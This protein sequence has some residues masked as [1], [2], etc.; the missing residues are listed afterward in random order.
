MA[1]VAL[2]VARERHHLSREF[3]REQRRAARDGVPQARTVRGGENVWLAEWVELDE[4]APA[5]LEYEAR[6]AEAESECIGAF[7]RTKARWAGGSRGEDA[8]TWYAAPHRDDF[9]FRTAMFGGVPAGAARER[10]RTRLRAGA[11][12]ALRV[13][14]TLR[15]A[16][17]AVDG[18][19]VARVALAPGDVPP[20]GYFGMVS[21]DTPWAFRGARVRAPRDDALHEPA[22]ARV[23]VRMLSG[24]AFELAVHLDDTARAVKRR[25][26]AARA[27]PRDQQRLAREGGAGL[28][29]DGARLGAAGVAAGDTLHLVVDASV[30]AAAA[31]PELRRR[32]CCAVS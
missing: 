3:E 10:R 25:I 27:I 22:D 26:E 2:A 13:E 6:P 24:D 1:G 17:Y 7:S 12:H 8:L 29:D 32:R 18:V 28:L 16:L 14:L 20:A 11:W 23:T 30:G 4:S 15:D 5:V 21:Y 9:A 31:K 19:V